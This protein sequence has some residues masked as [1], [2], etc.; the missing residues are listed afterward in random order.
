MG[1]LSTVV[2]RTTATPFVIRLASETIQMDR[3]TQNTEGSESLRRAKIDVSDPVQ[4]HEDR[5]IAQFIRSSVVMHH[6]NSNVRAEVLTTPELVKAAALIE[7][8]VQS[9]LV[10]EERRHEGGITRTLYDNLAS[11]C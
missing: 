7:A 5:L 8:A 2:G 11:R 6:T 4:P 1:A 9:F 10:K 3:Y